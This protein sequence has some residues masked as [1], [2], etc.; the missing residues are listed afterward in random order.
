MTNKTNKTTAPANDPESIYQEK[1][2][3]REKRYTQVPNL[4]IEYRNRLQISDQEMF[5]LLV[6]LNHW[7]QADKLPYPSVA[8]LAHMTG[9]TKRTVQRNLKS[10]A[11]NT[12]PKTSEWSSEVGYITVVPRYEESKNPQSGRNVDQKSNMFCFKKLIRALK[13]LEYEVSK[14]I[15]EVKAEAQSRQPSKP[16]R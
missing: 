6:L 12:V 8:T 10:L 5:L 15:K 16:S 11:T 4:L 2:G 7:W 14:G 1:W 3:L 9:R 13:C